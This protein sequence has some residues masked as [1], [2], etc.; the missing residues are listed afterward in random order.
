M[1]VAR[2]PAGSLGRVTAQA[3]MGGDGVGGGAVEAVAVVAVAPRG[4]G[5]AVAGVVLHVAQRQWPA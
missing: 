1:V 2:G 5:V 3:E 4:A